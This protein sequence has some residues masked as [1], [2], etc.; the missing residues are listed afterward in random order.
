[1][2]ADG[3]VVGTVA[4]SRP[5]GP[6]ATPRKSVL[7]VDD[8]ALIRTVVADVIS[9]LPDFRVA[10]TA[11]DGHEALEQIHALDPDIVTLDVDMPGLDGLDT[12]GY[13]MSETP[14]AVVMLSGA[15][16]A[17][18]VD[19]TLRALELGAVDFVHKHPQSGTRQV[20]EI[21]GRLE[22]ALR[23]AAVV[24]LRGAPMLLRHGAGQR[25]SPG[26]ASGTARVRAVV[27]IAAS[28]GGPRALAEII[29][30]L[31]ADLDAAVLVV[32]HM[33]PGFTQGLADRLQRAARLDVHEARHGERLAANHVY[34]APGGRHMT[35]HRD[36]AGACVSL[37]DSPPVWGVRPAADRLFRS[38]ADLFG[39]AALGVVL[40]GMGRDG[41]AGLAAIRRA[42]GG[43]LVQDAAT[44]TIN[45][46]PQ[47]ALDSAGADL[48]VPLAHVADSIRALLAERRMPL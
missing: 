40:T 41:S 42:G 32:Q 43:A 3:N 36:D 34:L 38:V 47:A 46:M 28:T 8:S 30:A 20:R 48:V 10:G 23:A 19:A 44:S 33:P 1:M 21:A 12:L 9:A 13:I 6:A 29:P 37:D 18:L 11:R 15:E 39:P 5:P 24:N 25:L 35:V 45:G 7:I 22:E 27:A 2:P 4:P 17:R 16:S 31:A 26:R 14:R